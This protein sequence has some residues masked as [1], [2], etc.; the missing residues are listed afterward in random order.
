MNNTLTILPETNIKTTWRIIAAIVFG[1]V[2][3]TTQWWDIKHTLE[4][5]SAILRDTI[6]TEDMVRFSMCLKTHNPIINVPEPVEYLHDGLAKRYE[7]GAEQL[8]QK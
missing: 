5:Q 7:H 6:R 3:F 2:V 8:E 4:Y 1:V